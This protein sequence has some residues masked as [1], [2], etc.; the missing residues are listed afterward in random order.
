[1][2]LTRTPTLEHRY[3]SRYEKSLYEE[4]HEQRKIVKKAWT[5]VIMKAITFVVASIGAGVG[6]AAA[7]AV[8]VATKI[9]KATADVGDEML[10]VATPILDAVQNGQSAV[11]GDPIAAAG[12]VLNVV[13]NIGGKV[14]GKIFTKT[15][16]QVAKKALQVAAAVLGMIF[17]I[18]KV[19]DGFFQ[20]F[21]KKKEYVVFEFSSSIEFVAVSRLRSVRVFVDN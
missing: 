7:K 19:V 8:T 21:D 5:D 11:L 13:K 16:K 20:M 15:L 9:V 12:V 6:I 3:T 18:I 1:M 4:I 14:G 2:T 17:M 10:Q